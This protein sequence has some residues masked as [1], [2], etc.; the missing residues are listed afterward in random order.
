MSLV[1]GLDLGTTNCKAVALSETGEVV[2]STASAYPLLTPQSGWAEQQAGDVWKGALA[3]L[4]NL[5]GQLPGGKVAGIA[6]SG[7]MHS[8]LAVDAAGNP[9]APAMTWADQRAAPQAATLRLRSDSKAMYQR[10]GCPLVPIYYPAKLLWLEEER[11]QIAK[12]ARFFMG[13]KDWIYYQLTGKW[14]MDKGLASTS[15]LL[16]IHRLQWDPE[17][18]SLTAVS[19]ERLPGLVS[20]FDARAGTLS[21]QA[22]SLCGLPAGLEVVPGSSDGV[23]ANIGVGAYAHGETVITVGTSGAIRRV[24]SNPLLDP[25]ERTWCYVIGQ[26]R[27]LAGGAINNGGLTLQWVRDYLYPDLPGETGYQQLLYDAAKILPGAEGLLLLPYFTGER[28]PYW[29]PSVRATL[30]GLGLEHSRGHIA[31]AALEG[32]A[33]CLADVWE[34]LGQ[35]GDAPDTTLRLTGG[36]TQAPLWAQIVSDVLGVRLGIVETA[37]ASAVGAAMLGHHALG[38]ASLETLTTQVSIRTVFNPNP[39]QHAIYRDLHRSFQ[40]MYQK[41]TSLNP[42]PESFGVN[43]S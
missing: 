27:W 6:L 29:N 25:Q 2:A 21:R 34:S 33:F 16:D 28:S 19:S 38:S 13:I 20:S 30:S 35:I 11:P 40:E 41:V 14:L 42:H 43:R 12:Q 37:D 7:A 32:V 5:S 4:K 8:L 39:G 18:L 26:D 31:R 36:I 17:A 9:L 15:G 22:A 10:T 3:A 23:L 1:I 24:V